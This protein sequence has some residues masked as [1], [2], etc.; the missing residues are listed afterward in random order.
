[1]FA[2]QRTIDRIVFLRI[3]EDRRIE[4]YGRLMALLNGEHTYARLQRLFREADERY[5]SGLFHFQKE[6]D[7]VE[8]PDELTPGLEIDDAVLKKIIRRLYYPESPYEFS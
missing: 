7:R 4:V 5:N 1:N 2:V 3:C 6:K 8:P